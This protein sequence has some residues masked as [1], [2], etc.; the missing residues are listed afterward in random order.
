MKQLLNASILAVCLT[1]LVLPALP[2]QGPVVVWPCNGVVQVAHDSKGS[3][4]RYT[5]DLLGGAWSED[6]ALSQAAATYHGNITCMNECLPPLGCYKSIDWT[7]DQVLYIS[8][9]GGASG[10]EFTYSIKNFKVTGYCLQC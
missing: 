7:Y 3:S 4:N 2:V 9:P 8:G 10:N 5:S 6:C 1:Q